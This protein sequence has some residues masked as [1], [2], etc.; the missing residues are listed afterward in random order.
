MATT[1]ELPPSAGKGQNFIHNSKTTDVPETK[2]QIRLVFRAAND[3]KVI[4]RPAL[5][6]TCICN[7][8]YA[9]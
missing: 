1:G 3:K 7:T 9:V 2:G 6:R 5:L 8:K 4:L